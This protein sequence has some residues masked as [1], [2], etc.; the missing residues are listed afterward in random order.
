M[1][2]DYDAKDPAPTSTVGMMRNIS[3]SM[4]NVYADNACEVRG[5][6]SRL[7]KYAT[8]QTSSPDV[9][10]TTQALVYYAFEGVTGV[11]T[12]QGYLVVEYDVEFFTPQ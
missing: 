2:V 12:S 9:D 3:S 6:L 8:G 5:S 11:N 4:S 1:A 10:Q 7:P